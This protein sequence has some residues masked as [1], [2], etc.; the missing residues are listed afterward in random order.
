MTFPTLESPRRIGRRQRAAQMEARMLKHSAIYNSA[1]LLRDA[2]HGSDERRAQCASV[3]A[4][5]VRE[6]LQAPQCDCEAVLYAT[7]DAICCSPMG[8]PWEA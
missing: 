7:A 5:A 1:A 3:M 8:T 6:A 2:W 4:Q